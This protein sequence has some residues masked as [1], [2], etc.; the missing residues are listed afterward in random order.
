MSDL[1]LKEEGRGRVDLISPED[2]EAECVKDKS[3]YAQTAHEYAVHGEEIQ[4]TARL[5]HD[6]S[7]WPHV[8]WRG[9]YWLA[10][11]FTNDRSGVSFGR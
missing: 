2:G 7:V 10:D 6:T 3:Y 9:N 8:I 1:H 11:Q 4:V 5:V